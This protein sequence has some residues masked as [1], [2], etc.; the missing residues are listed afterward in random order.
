MVKRTQEIRT[1][2]S[3]SQL[4]DRSHRELYRLA[5]EVNGF[6]KLAATAKDVLSDKAFAEGVEIL[7]DPK[8][9]TDRLLAYLGGSHELI[10]GMAAAAL[11]N[12]GIESNHREQV[13]GNLSAKV[14]ITLDFSLQALHKSFGGEAGLAGRVLLECVV[15]SPAFTGWKVIRRFLEDRIVAGDDPCSGTWANELTDEERQQFSERV[16]KVGGQ[17]GRRIC[18]WIAGKGSV[19]TD[20]GFLKKIGKVLEADELGD[21]EGVIRHKDLTRAIKRGQG[22]LEGDHLNS[23]LYV[24]KPGAGKKTALRV[25]LDQMVN[26]EWLVLELSA[27][28]LIAGQSDVGQIEDRVER[29]SSCLMSSD[30]SVWYVPDISA[31]ITAGQHSKSD[32]GVLDM[33]TPHMRSG[34]LRLIGA[35]SPAEAERL[36][37]SYSGQL[38]LFQEIGISDLTLDAARALAVK[39]SAAQS[40]HSRGVKVGRSMVDRVCKYMGHY[41]HDIPLPGGLFNVLHIA[42]QRARGRAQDPVKNIR[43]TEKDLIGALESKLGVPGHILKPT[44]PYSREMVEDALGHDLKGQDEAIRSISGQLACVLSGLAKNEYHPLGV[45]LF[46][47]GTGTGKTELAKSIAALISG[48]RD[49]LIRVD[50]SEM[51]GESSLSRILGHSW[52]GGLSLVSRIRQ[53]P[54]SVVLLDEFEKSHPVIRNVFLQA[55]D[56]G[57]LT[58]A[59]GIEASCRNCLF[60][61]TSNLGRGLGSGTVGF[62]DTETAQS[63]SLQKALR[64][65]LPPELRNRISE[66]VEFGSLSADALGLILN[67]QIE[68]I[69]SIPRISSSGV[70]IK[71][72]VGAREY[73]ITKAIQENLGARPLV[74]AVEKD[75]LGAILEFITMQGSLPAGGDLHVSL[76][77]EKGL[78]VCKSLPTHCRDLKLV[79]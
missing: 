66:M 78:L 9:S 24:G 10:Q 5:E 17:L 23:F 22:V 38:P 47:G 25:L 51:N 58:D 70:S 34:R 35:V 28:Q 67:K 61:L 20:I 76:D 64:V 30:K 42:V 49:R 52:G 37:L 6:F 57:R 1:T 15:E 3:Y 8:F 55:F 12:R 31:L 40:K 63:R 59:H 65:E 62:E 33:I 14:A 68:G 29:I 21:Q 2:D 60:I 39:W 13:I 56:E 71:L 74:R 4:N 50:M 43:V 69:H 27:T 46:A 36:R 44:K 7:S 75:V 54:Y 72:S 11:L 41:G 18:K 32:I 45:F 73:L 26:D 79:A 53:R 48:S 77:N 19:C 16:A